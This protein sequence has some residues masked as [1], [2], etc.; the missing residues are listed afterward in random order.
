MWFEACSSNPCW[1]L[2]EDVGGWS[3]CGSICQQLSSVSLHPCAIAASSHLF[4]LHF[5]LSLFVSHLLPHLNSLFL[6]TLSLS[7]H[8]CSLLSFFKCPSPSV[9][10]SP[11]SCPL[12]YSFTYLSSVSASFPTYF[13]LAIFF[14]SKSLSSSPL[15]PSTPLSFF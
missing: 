15:T 8:P 3:L 9:N 11:L 10:H 14:R 2:E 7:F 12:F 13:S 1:G 5:H 6:F 4:S